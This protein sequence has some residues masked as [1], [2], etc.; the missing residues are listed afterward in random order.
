M[1]PLDTAMR[2]AAMF[3]ALDWISLARMSCKA[4]YGVLGLSVAEGLRTSAN[5]RR[6]PV[7]VIPSGVRA[8]HPKVP[9]QPPEPLHMLSS[10]FRE[11]LPEVFL[12]GMWLLW[13]SDRG[14][15]ACRC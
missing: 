5:S 7:H 13:L 1:S 14:R 6:V 11:S 2:A 15:A 12:L 9:K 4:P 3:S 8:A 10:C